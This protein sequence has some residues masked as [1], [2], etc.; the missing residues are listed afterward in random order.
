M[1]KEKELICV[2]SKDTPFP[3]PCL[4][5]RRYVFCRIAKKFLPIEEFVSAIS[6]H[7]KTFG[8]WGAV[9]LHVSKYGSLPESIRLEDLPEEVRK[10]IKRMLN[11]KAVHYRV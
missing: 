9:A 8:H 7:T 1:K 5:P 10:D 6:L 3:S 2:F 4:N 11:K